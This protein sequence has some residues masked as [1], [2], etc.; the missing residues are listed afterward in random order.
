MGYTSG[1]QR[2]NTDLC[3]HYTCIARPITHVML[4]VP[5][6]RNRTPASRSSSWWPW[7]FCRPGA[8]ATHWTC[9][10]GWAAAPAGSSWPR[11]CHGG[12]G[13]AYRSRDGEGKCIKLLWL[14]DD[15]D[16][17]YDCLWIRR[18]T[19]FCCILMNA[20]TISWLTRGICLKIICE[21]KCY[22]DYA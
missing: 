17:E 9:S 21:R 3:M 7:R 19:M 14:D 10:A 6:I 12:T 5:Y 8:T 4:I 2:K 1:Y 18:D 13:T 22:L 15:L 16:G 20:E 11:N